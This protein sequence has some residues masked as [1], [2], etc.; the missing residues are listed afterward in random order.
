MSLL[1]WRQLRQGLSK[2]LP[3]QG[4]H[5][6]WG[7]LA[8]HSV[9]CYGVLSKPVV[10]PVVIDIGLQGIPYDKGVSGMPNLNYVALPDNLINELATFRE[11]VPFEHVAILSNAALV[12][13]IPELPER[14]SRSLFGFDIGFDFID[15]V[16]IRF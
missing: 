7:L 13:A 9:C 3:L 4:R 15:E 11:V 1:R 5:L 2:T 10:A 8:S 12:D 16:L 14:T 6:T